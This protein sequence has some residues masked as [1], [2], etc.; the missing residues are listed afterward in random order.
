M[1]IDV[2]QIDFSKIDLEEIISGV[3][4]VAA[5]S[6][7]SEVQSIWPVKTGKSRGA[8]ESS[9][10]SNKDSVSLIISNAV[11]YVPFIHPKG[12]KTLSTK[13]ADK[14]LQDNADQ[15]NEKIIAAI[16]EAFNNIKAT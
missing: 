1:K 2:Q 12:D 5:P 7:V 14:D 3:L 4:R 6:V 11:D 13:I 16:T 9:I 10:S 15:I 8:M